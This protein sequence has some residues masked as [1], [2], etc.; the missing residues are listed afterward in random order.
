MLTEAKEEVGGI[1]LYKLQLMPDVKMSCLA[2]S[3]TLAKYI[4]DEK[5]TCS[6]VH[7]LPCSSC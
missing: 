3:D 5:Q 1:L 6:P 2:L 7:L 4:L